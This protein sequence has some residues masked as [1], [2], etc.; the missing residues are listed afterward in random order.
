MVLVLAHREYGGWNSRFLDDIRVSARYIEQPYQS[1]WNATD[2]VKRAGVEA[3]IVHLRSQ[4]DALA[5]KN[6][7]GYLPGLSSLL[8]H[9]AVMRIYNRI[10][11]ENLAGVD[12]CIAFIN[13]YSQVQDSYLVFAHEGRH[14][15]DKR[16][17][18]SKYASWGAMEQERRAKLS[19]IVFAA[20][21]KLAFTGILSPYIGDPKMPHAI[22]DEM[23]VKG[24][25]QWM[26][27]NSG[28]I[29]GLNP[30]RPLL[31]QFNLLS[32]EQVRQIARNLDPLADGK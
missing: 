27:A 19:Q 23:I 22:A 31:P 5:A 32:D 15:I 20:D 26:S 4:D 16:S 24:Y 28:K 25:V 13:E 18:P 14:L 17:F 11:A 2:E 12:L 10:A 7:Y 30:S 6:P 1:W 29:P 8:S 21:P 3:Q 9:E